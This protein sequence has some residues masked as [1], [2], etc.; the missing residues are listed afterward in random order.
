MFLLA[1]FPNGVFFF[2]IDRDYY[3][4]V[5]KGCQKMF[6]LNLSSIQNRFPIK[7]RPF[8]YIL[9]INGHQN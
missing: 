4:V 1:I 3:F 2:F 6:V 7:I 5:K 8:Y 9:P